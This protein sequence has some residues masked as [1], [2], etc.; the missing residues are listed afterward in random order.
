MASEE[1]RDVP[2][3]GQ[4]NVVDVDSASAGLVTM[5][6]RFRSGQRDPLIFGEGRPEGVVLAFEGWLDLLSAAEDQQTSQRVVR[7]TR[8]RVDTPREDYVPIEDLGLD[9][10]DEDSRRE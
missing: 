6:Q 3:R 7:T 2:G 10:D 1:I 5:L 4:V 9:L 8:E